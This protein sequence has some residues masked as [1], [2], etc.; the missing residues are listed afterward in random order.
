MGYDKWK[1]ECGVFGVSL[2]DDEA[3]GLTYN[4]LL[5]LQHRG[6]ESAGIAV[7]ADRSIR[8][9]KEQGL[10]GEVFSHEQLKGLPASSMGVGHAR[11]S[12]AARNSRDNAQPMIVDYLKGRL[13]L[14]NNGHLVNSA[15]IKKG[16]EERG[17]D[18]IAATD[19]EIMATLIAMEALACDEIE[20]AVA[21]A[22]RQFKGAFSLIVLSS[23]GKLVALRDGCGFRPL[24][25]GRGGSG[26]AVASESCA[27]DST[28]FEL[29]R[30]VKPGEML[31]IDRAQNMSSRQ[32]LEAGQ[33]GLCIFEYVYTA[34]PDSVIDALS[35]YQA[36]FRAGQILAKEHPVEADVVCALPDSGLEAAQ[37]YSAG[38]GIPYITGFLKNRYIGRTFIY[39]SQMQRE[40]AVRV[41][42]NPLK[43]NVA[44]KKVVVVDDSIVRGT[45]TDKTIQSLKDTGA[46]EV[47]LRI[48]SPPFKHTCHFGTDI[49]HEENLIANQFSLEG[50]C[51]RIG[52]DSLGYI[53]LDGLKAACSGC[54]LPFCAGC[55]TGE[56][57]LALY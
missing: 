50:L 41:K 23:Q 18:F 8:C 52:A 35:V 22:S 39:P 20:D 56:Y 55:F 33:Q 11:Y 19:T 28:G 29:I 27:L 38:S 24:C 17:C 36:R 6:Q 42:L 34:R 54:T 47:H 16:L 9:I 32:I 43:A 4:A 53:S 57:P 12:T 13:A 25:I 3:A 2:T 49:D 48:A 51:R 46:A 26:L 37:G 14:V 7:L 30:D 5:A 40:A 1:E 21:S 45:T 44:G 31:I 10:V 15:E